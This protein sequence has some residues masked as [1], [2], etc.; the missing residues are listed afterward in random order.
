M[1]LEVIGKGSQYL[2]GLRDVNGD[3]LQGDRTYTLRVPPNVPSADFWSVVLYDPQTRC[4]LQTPNMP[5]PGRH[6]K[7][8][9]FIVDD[10]GVTLY[11]SP[12][13]PGGRESNWIQTVPGKGW[14]CAFHNYGPLE[15]W[16]DKTWK[17]DDVTPVD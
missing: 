15:A 5:F 13:P 16:F 1:V 14:Y 17:L 7:K 3:Y 9:D 8:D 6:N 2:V 10:G 11:F 12:E 4:L